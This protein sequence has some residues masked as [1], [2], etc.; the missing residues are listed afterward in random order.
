MEVMGDQLARP[1]TPASGSLQW[2]ITSLRYMV[3]PKISG[4]HNETLPQNNTKM[5]GGECEVGVL[6]M[7][8]GERRTGKGRWV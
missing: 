5:E 8:T 7:W 6:R 2:K 4:R 1:V 3:K